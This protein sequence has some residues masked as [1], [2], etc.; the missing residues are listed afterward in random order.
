MGVGAA[1]QFHTPA[2]LRSRHLAVV[3][4]LARATDEALVTPLALGAPGLGE[5][6]LGEV[7]LGVHLVVE[8]VSRQLR[9]ITN[10]DLCG[11]RHSWSL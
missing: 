8:E 10:L 11:A 7:L 3:P 4:I 5:G 9:P 1:P 2:G 6:P